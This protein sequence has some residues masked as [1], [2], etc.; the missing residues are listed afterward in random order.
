[1]NQK[2]TPLALA[3]SIQFV[4]EIDKL[5]GSCEKCGQLAKN[6]TGTQRSIA[7]RSRYSPCSWIVR[8]N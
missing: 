6:V 1:M 8:W 3:K 7:D 2:T 5:K 4:L